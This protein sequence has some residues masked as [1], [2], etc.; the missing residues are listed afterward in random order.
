MAKKK[1]DF[2]Q[3]VQRLAEIVALMERADTPLEK[4]VELY[5][6]GV[7]LS[8]V[9]DKILNDAENQV[10]VLSKTADGI[11]YEAPFDLSEERT[12]EF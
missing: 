9:C 11:F 12:D 5:K 10:S 6:E 3:T 4:S 8:L 7:E 1:M 2:E